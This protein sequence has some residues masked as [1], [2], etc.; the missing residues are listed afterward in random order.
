MR[1]ERLQPHAVVHDH[2]VAVDA[3]LVGEEHLPRL[4]A[5]IDT[6][7]RRQVEPEVHL[8]VDFLALYM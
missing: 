7:E 4:A 6:G 3:E 1:V 2:T 8:L 5:T